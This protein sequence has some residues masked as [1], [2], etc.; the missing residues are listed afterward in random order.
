MSSVLFQSA[1]GALGCLF[2]VVSGLLHV[3]LGLLGCALCLGFA[4]S[5]DLPSGFLHGTNGFVLV[6][7]HLSSDGWWSTGEVCG[8]ERIVETLG[9]VRRIC[10]GAVFL[11]ETMERSF[12]PRPVR[13]EA[14]PS[15]Q[16][17][18]WNGV[19]KEGCWFK[20]A[21]SEGANSPHM[22]EC[23]D[24][25][26]I[27]FGAPSL[28]FRTAGSQFERLEL[29]PSPRDPG[30]GRYK[31]PERVPSSPSR[32]DRQHRFDG[33]DRPW[34]RAPG[35]QVEGEYEIPVRQGC[36]G[37]DLHYSLPDRGSRKDFSKSIKSRLNA[38]QAWPKAADPEVGTRRWTRGLRR[39][40]ALKFSRTSSIFYIY[41]FY[42]SAHLN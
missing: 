28:S 18:F 26:R 39:R 3:T 27:S 35:N 30:A 8:E 21:A 2:D 41:L 14:T 29:R 33:D 1:S 15:S 38:Q 34:R 12:L 42:Y 7:G 9:S 23:A 5:G 24:S 40:Q 31:S 10:Q 25:N 32:A 6:P 16:H 20:S 13:A 11:P 17:C 37:S 4:V 36:N 22:R 19:P